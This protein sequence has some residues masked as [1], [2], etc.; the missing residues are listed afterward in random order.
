MFFAKQKENRVEE[1][2]KNFF[3]VKASSFKKRKPYNYQKIFKS[4]RA[5]SFETMPGPIRREIEPAV[6]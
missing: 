3:Y 1:K 5:G 4:D 2:E 6:E